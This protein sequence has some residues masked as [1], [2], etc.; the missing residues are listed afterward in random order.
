MIIAIVIKKN[1]KKNR[2]SL[3]NIELDF[4]ETNV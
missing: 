3:I 2:L 4:C 1:E